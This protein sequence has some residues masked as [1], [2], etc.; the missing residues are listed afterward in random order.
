MQ[1]GVGLRSTKYFV[2]RILCFSYRMKRELVLLTIAFLCCLTSGKISIISIIYVHCTL[3]AIFLEKSLSFADKGHDSKSAVSV[4][5]ERG[6]THNIKKWLFSNRHRYFNFVACCRSK[7]QHS[8][9]KSASVSYTLCCSPVK[10]PSNIHRGPLKKV[11]IFYDNFGK[12]GPIS[13]M[14]KFFILL[15]TTNW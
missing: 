12:C 9:R 7:A 2:S 5:G 6:K 4:A 11:P 1:T 3:V 15:S 14:I 10:W 13:I 8:E